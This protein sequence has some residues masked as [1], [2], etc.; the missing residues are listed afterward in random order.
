MKN[1]MKQLL[2]VAALATQSVSAITFA[3]VKK[4][5]VEKA[6]AVKDTVVGAP[7]TS[8]CGLATVLAAAG[9]VGVKVAAKRMRKKNGKLTR[10]M[11]VANKYAVL[12][13]A[14]LAAVTAYGVAHNKFDGSTTVTGDSKTAKALRAL[15]WAN[16]APQV[17]SAREGVA[18]TMTELEKNKT[19]L[20]TAEA[21]KAAATGDTTEIETAIAEHKTKL[22][23]SERAV[24]EAQAALAAELAKLTPAAA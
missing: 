16:E 10:A 12:V 20:A 2:V 19:A 14:F 4:S 5:C 3:D 1:T 6:T 7:K 24:G 13:P 11:E 17:K 9:V 23:D 15:L 18:N 8:L 22:A 21:Q